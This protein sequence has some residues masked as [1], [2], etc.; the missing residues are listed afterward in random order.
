MTNLK[1]KA[2][3]GP[4]RKYL[5]SFLFC[6][7]LGLDGCASSA[8]APISEQSTRNNC[9][10]LLYQLLNEEKDVKFL[11][12]IRPE[13]TDAKNLT[14]KISAAS[15]GGVDTLEEL[16][17][18]DA[19]INLH[20]LRLPSGEVKTRDAISK[21]KEHNLLHQKGDELELSLLLSQYE[22]L[23]YGWKLAQTAAVNEP[24]PDRARALNRLG[25]ELEDL[26]QDVYVMF[27]SKIKSAESNRRH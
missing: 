22:A 19:S 15:L 10:S 16:A 8:R 2:D 5:F 17:K 26:Y 23:Q 24:N 1:R 11:R 6:A 7:V 27:L 4:A 21:F 20:D 9:Y 13:D 18:E 3:F 12:F 25:N 14:R